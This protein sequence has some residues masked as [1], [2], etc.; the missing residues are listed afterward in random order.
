MNIR[1]IIFSGIIT[2]LL[3]GIFGIAIAEITKQP[4]QCCPTEKMDLGFSRP[5]RS[6]TY[7]IIGAIAGFTVG[8]V[9]ASLRQ[10]IEENENIEE[11]NDQES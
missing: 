2:A 3:G 4:Y 7:G 10:T 6:R 9:Q 8:V 5:R 11:N 1:I